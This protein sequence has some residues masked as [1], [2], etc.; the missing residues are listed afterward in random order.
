[1]IEKNGKSEL[2]QKLLTPA[3]RDND[4]QTG[5]VVV[6]VASRKDKISVVNNSRI[7][8]EIFRSALMHIIAVLKENNS[9]ALTGNI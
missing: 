7:L 3:S 5:V 1:M 8:K 9:R 6:V 4:I 2:E